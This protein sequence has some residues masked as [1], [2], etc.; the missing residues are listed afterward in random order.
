MRRWLDR[1]ITLRPEPGPKAAGGSS[2]RRAFCL[3]LMATTAVMLVMYIFITASAN[4]DIKDHPDNLKL[5]ALNAMGWDQ[6]ECYNWLIIGESNW[7]PKARNGSHY[8]LAQMRNAKV[9]R[10][11]GRTQIDWHLRYLEHR[12]KGCAC[13]A[14]AHLEAKGWH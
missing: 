10:L 8:G 3:R 9:A 1:V 2:V 11:D 4:A 14:L 5:Y 12:Y 7:N 6:F 13:R